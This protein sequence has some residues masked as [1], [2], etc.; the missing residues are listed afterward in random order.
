MRR[1]VSMGI[2][3]LIIGSALALGLLFI[4]LGVRAIDEDSGI[5]DRGTVSLAPGS[6]Q[7]AQQKEEVGAETDEP[8][9][10]AAKA[11]GPTYQFVLRVEKG[12][13]YVY[14]TAGNRLFMDTGFK[15]RELPDHVQ[16]KVREGLGF[17]TEEELF[18]F[19]ESY[20]S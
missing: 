6:R 15:L 1:Q 18:A 16:R 5:W 4:S 10:T 2:F 8:S 7:A 19:L 12:E 20:S 9:V 17:Q 11:V 13:I 3:I 14:E